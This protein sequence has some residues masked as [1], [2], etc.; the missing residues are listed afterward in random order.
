MESSATR[1]IRSKRVG[2]ISR[3][4]I[5]DADKSTTTTR[6]QIMVSR[7]GAST[8]NQRLEKENVSSIVFTVFVGIGPW[9]VACLNFL[10]SVPRTRKVCMP[11]KTDFGI[12][13]A[14]AR[15]VRRCLIPCTRQS[16][17]SRTNFPKGSVHTSR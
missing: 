13:P 12:Q 9:F 2:R 1:S 7:I 6:W 5:D 3:S 15:L 14:R 17:I 8:V 11:V 4:I 16:H 10:H